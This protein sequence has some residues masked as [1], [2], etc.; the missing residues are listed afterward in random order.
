MGSSLSLPLLD[1]M[2][3]AATALAA[4]AAKPVSRF[5]VVYV[6]NGMIMQNYLPKAEG[7]AYE[8]TP[9]LSTLAPFRN[10]LLILS[11]L[12][13]TPTPGRSGGAHAKA[14]TRF[15]TD[16]SPPTSETRLDAG[17]SMDQILAKELGKHTQLASLELAIESGDTAGA[18][19]QGF[20]CAYTNT[21]CWRSANTPLPT[22]NNPRAVFERLFGDTGSTDPKAQLA[23]IRH[24]RSVLDSV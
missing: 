22:Q 4:T 5:G 10:D 3:P 13:C 19:D 2:I 8:L 17:I 23:R 1:S 6:P 15:L 9:T 21:I 16:V 14:S 7:A 12:N 11:G 18:C 24:E 20:A